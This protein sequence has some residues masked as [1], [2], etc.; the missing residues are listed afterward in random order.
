VVTDPL[1]LVLLAILRRWRYGIAVRSG[2]G[3]DVLVV[4]VLRLRVGVIFVIFLVVVP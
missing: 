4:V 1:L 3:S 2:W